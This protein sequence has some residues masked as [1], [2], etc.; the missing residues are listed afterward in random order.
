MSDFKNFVEYI[1]TLDIKKCDI[2]IRLQSELIDLNNVDYIGRFENF[3]TDFKEILSILDIN[4]FE[5]E[6]INASN[7]GKHYKEYY[8]D[9]LRDKVAK[10][11]SK[12]I[13]L[14]SYS[15]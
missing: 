5:I 6:R 1:S 4:E 9:E 15:F 10:I 13:M 2:H 11:Y 14:L 8:D 7:I 3:D 12:D